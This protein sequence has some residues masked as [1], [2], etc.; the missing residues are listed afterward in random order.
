MAGRPPHEQARRR[1]RRVRTRRQ[2]RAIS[3]PEYHERPEV[4]WHCVVVEIAIDDIPQP[5]PLNSDRL[6]QAPPH[7]LLNHLELRSH[8]VPAKEHAARH[9]DG[10]AQRDQRE[11]WRAARK[12]MF[13]CG[14]A[15]ARGPVGRHGDFYLGQ[16]IDDHLRQDSTIESFVGRLFR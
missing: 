7:L 13:A 4:G 9:A 3:L 14:S 12:G 8:A 16:V 2:R 11:L 15:L 6:V 10:P 5:F 1:L